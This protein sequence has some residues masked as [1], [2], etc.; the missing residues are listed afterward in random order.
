MSATR[1]GAIGTSGHSPGGSALL[2]AAFS[3]AALAVLVAVAFSL[4]ALAL[5]P[6]LGVA[7]AALQHSALRLARS[8]DLRLADALVGLRLHWRRGL[9]LGLLDLLVVAAGVWALLA[10]GSQDSALWPLAFVVGYLL[11]TFAVLQVHLWP[12]AVGRPHASLRA[13]LGEAV[14]ALVRRPGA[15]VSLAAVLAAVNLLGIAAAVMPFLTLTVAFSFL[16][17]AHF[18]VPTERQA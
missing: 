1:G 4:L 9:T 13:V 8:G 10:Y 17:A 3:L 5:A 12:L 6:L 11:L 7:A 18:A 2:N 15:T 16:A 14:M